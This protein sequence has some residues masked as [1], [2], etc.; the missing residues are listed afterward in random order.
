MSIVLPSVTVGEIDKASFKFGQNPKLTI[1]SV[2]Y[3]ACQVHKEA[4]F[5]LSSK[6]QILCIALIAFEF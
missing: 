5:V 1:L 2:A 4:N 3:H 6:T